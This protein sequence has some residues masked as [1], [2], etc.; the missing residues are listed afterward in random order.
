MTGRARV[1]VTER[2]AVAAV[3][4]GQIHAGDIIVLICRGPIGAGMEAVLFLEGQESV[5]VAVDEQGLPELL[6]AVAAKENARVDD[7]IRSGR[8]VRVAN[9]T[10]VQV[11]EMAAGKTKVRIIEGERAMQTGWVV[12][13]WVR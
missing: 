6:G 13:R 11:L 1:F 4:K 7:L 12:D 3:K 10:R 2:A 8:V 5:F 9:N